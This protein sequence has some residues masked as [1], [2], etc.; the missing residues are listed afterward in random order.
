[1]IKDLKLNPDSETAVVA[2]DNGNDLTV[3]TVYTMFIELVMQMLTI[4][5][6]QADTGIFYLCTSF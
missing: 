1:M 2:S 3:A 6:L 4:L 5:Q